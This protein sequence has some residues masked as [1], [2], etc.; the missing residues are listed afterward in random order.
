MTATNP[1]GDIFNEINIGTVNS[2]DIVLG[3]LSHND[4]TNIELSLEKAAGGLKKYY[5]DLTSVVVNSDCCSEDKTKELFLSSKTEVP[6]IY[7]STPPDRN[8]KRT[9]FFNL[10]QIAQRLNPKVILALDAR[11]STVK[12][13]WVPR[14]A[15]PILKNGAI[16]TAPIYSRQ[17]FDTPVTFL[18]TYPMF[19]AIFGRRIRHPNMG[20]AAFSGALNDTL[21]NNTTWPSEEG[22]AA[23]ELTM[24]VIAVSQGPVFQSFMGDP[25]VGHVRTPIDVHITEEFYSNL[26][27]LYELMDIYPKLWLKVKNSRPTPI[28][29]ADL[30][31]EILAPRVMTIAPE[32]AETI[33]L[34]ISKEA[35]SLWAKHFTEYLPLLEKLK[36]S[37]LDSIEIDPE[38]WVKIIYKGSVVF[39]TLNESE[40]CILV[41]S[42]IPLFLV[43]LFKFHKMTCSLT[44]GQLISMTED[45]ALIFEKFKPDLSFVWKSMDSKL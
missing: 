23:C 36:T 39:R 10:M 43:R 28:L 12:M 29:G 21:L 14:L 35:E 33:I 13:S 45:E 17:F 19:R 41:R 34:N 16:Y 7:V 25:R 2:A 20:D 18:L 37:P 4:M 40:R 44:S 9:S 8:L 15:E 27:T 3:I 11:I 32:T 22:F 1:G 38:I 6:R 5:P 26:K 30:K 31:P 24:Q 42:I